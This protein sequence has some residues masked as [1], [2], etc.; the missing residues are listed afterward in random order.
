MSAVKWL[1]LPSWFY[2]IQFWGSVLF[3]AEEHFVDAGYHP[4]VNIFRCSNCELQWCYAFEGW[5]MYT[6]IAALS[7]CRIRPALGACLSESRTIS[8]RFCF[9]CIYQEVGHYRRRYWAVSCFLVCQSI[10]SAG[11]ESSHRCRGDACWLSYYEKISATYTLLSIDISYG[12]FTLFSGEQHPSEALDISL[13]FPTKYIS[14][15]FPAS[16]RPWR[17]RCNG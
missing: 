9:L 13:V 17:L 7:F 10:E 14:S 16:N 15:V 12:T 8:S 3:V 6:S 5:D 11:S 4:H 1:H 2:C